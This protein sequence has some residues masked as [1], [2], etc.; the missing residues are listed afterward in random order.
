MR[1]LR[2]FLLW[3]AGLAAP[4]TQTTAAERDCLARHAAGRRRVAEIGVWHGV[5]TCRLRAAL[6]ADGVLF[7]VDPFPRGRLGMSFQRVIAHRE[8]G[9]VPNGSVRWLEMTGAEAARAVEPGV[10]LVFIDGDHSYEGL[11]ADW[12]AWADRVAVGGVVALHDSRDTPERRI[13]GAGS[14]RYTSE[15]ILH[16]PRFTAIEAVDSLTVVRRRS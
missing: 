12:E 16:D 15:H 9:R 1:V 13:A 3:S 7:A 11:R 4:E 10:D 14:V 8:V 2:H 5:T 6:A